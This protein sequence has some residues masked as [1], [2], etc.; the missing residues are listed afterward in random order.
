MAYGIRGH[1]GIAKETSWGT[2]VAATDY[3]KLLN[4]GLATGFDRYDITNIHGSVAEPDDMQGVTRVEGDI[5]FAGHPV[6]VGYM[7]KSAFVQSSVQSIGANLWKTTFATPSADFADGSCAGTPYTLEI[8]RDVTSSMR[9]YGCAVNRLVMGFAPNQDVR[10]TAGFIAKGGSLIAKTTP[11]YP[12]SPAKPFSFESVSLSIAGAGT[13]RIEALTVTIENQLEGI[14]ALNLTQDIAKIL[15][16]GPQ[17]ITVGGTMDFPDVTQYLDFV[18]QT[19]VALAVSAFRANSFQLTVEI[20][21]MVYTAFPV[22]LRGR[23]RI[24]V[25]FTGKGYYH[26]GSGNAI[27]VALTTVKSDY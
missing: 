22:S 26:T 15:R 7:L 4:E 3:I 18:N 27:K 1:L 13:T 11:T 20:P 16:R 24:T 17:M 19:E 2:P 9:Y 10:F 12:S 6:S 8:Y 5:E 23:E 14:P 25:D 21:R